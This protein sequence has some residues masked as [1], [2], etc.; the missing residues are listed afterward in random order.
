MVAK[1]LSA[2]LA[3]DCAVVVKPSE[4]T[5][6]SMIALFELL[7]RVGLPRGRANLVIGN[8]APIG[9]LLCEHPEVSVISFTGSTPVGR[10]LL[11]KTADQVKRLALELGGNAPFIVFE[12]ADVPAAARELVQ[13]K[14]RASGQTCV[15]TNRVL[16]HHSAANAF[17]SAL[18]EELKG[19]RAGDG[20]DPDTDLGPLHRPGG[21]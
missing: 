20:M 7:R 11:R 8:P 15:C 1:K 13:N 12:D 9:D 6:L 14:L 5:P 4:K 17:T 3:A 2:A 16:V 21:L 19:L 18:I 10:M